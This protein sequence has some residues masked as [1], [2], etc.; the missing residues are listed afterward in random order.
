MNTLTAL[1]LKGRGLLLCLLLTFLATKG[2][3]Q[4]LQYPRAYDQ[5][6]V[7]YDDTSVK[8][9]QNSCLHNPVRFTFGVSATRCVFAGY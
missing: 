1:V 8:I 6:F 4:C 7:C 2:I 3:T 5:V 9:E